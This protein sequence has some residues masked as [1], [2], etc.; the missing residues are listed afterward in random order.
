M[1][2]QAPVCPAGTLGTPTG[3]VVNDNSEFVI[4]K[5]GKSGPAFFI[6]ATLDGTISGWNPEVD[7][8]H[9]VIMVDYSKKRPYGRQLHETASREK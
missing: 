1:F 5:N 7:L 8:H 3:F 6:F 2:R 9:A 4:S